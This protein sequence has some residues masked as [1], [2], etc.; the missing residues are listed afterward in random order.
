M[1]EAELLTWALS[2][3]I[4]DAPSAATPCIGH[5]LTISNFPEAGGRGLAAARDLKEGELILVV[6]QTALLN[7]DSFEGD[8]HVKKALQLFP[9]FSSFQ[10][11]VALLLR[12]VWKGSLSRWFVYLKTLPRSYHTFVQYSNYEIQA[13]Q[14]DDA[15]WTA[16]HAVATAH[17]EWIETKPFLGILGLKGRFVTFKAWQWACSTVSSRTLHVPWSSAGTLCPMGD[18]FNY[19]PPG[20]T[21]AEGTKTPSYCNLSDTHVE[22]LFLVEEM[23][24]VEGSELDKDEAGGDL[25]FTDRL[26]DGGFDLNSCCYYFYARENYKKGDQVLLC[27]GLHT[28][29]D[30]LQHYGFILPDNPNDKVFIRLDDFS[31]FTPTLLPEQLTAWMKHGS[32]HIEVDGRPSFQFLAVLRLYFAPGEVRQHK[33][34]LALSGQQL[35]VENDIIVYQ[36]LKETCSTILKKFPSTMLMDSALGH[37]ICL[38]SSFDGLTGVDIRCVHKLL[39]TRRSCKKVSGQDQQPAT[40]HA[41]GSSKTRVCLLPLSR[42]SN[43]TV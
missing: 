26:T 43:D 36:Q 15:V 23:G 5:S 30:L 19:A 27:Y 4:T 42:S 10:I 17:K 13:L 7:V 32:M 14:A 12:E 29:L 11:L 31:G 35:C 28:N 41:V 8:V 1:A 9:H 20:N 39:S 37:I 18:L 22:N 2:N 33:G 16:E 25:Y 3:G 38:C 6:P 21:H 40:F 24:L 34:H